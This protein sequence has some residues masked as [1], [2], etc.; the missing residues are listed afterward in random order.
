MALSHTTLMVLTRD[1]ELLSFWHAAGVTVAGAAPRRPDGIALRLRQTARRLGRPVVGEVFAAGALDLRLD[2]FRELVRRP[3]ATLIG[4]SS[5]LV[6]LPLLTLALFGLS[7]LFFR[8]FSPH[9]E[10]FF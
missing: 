5:Q 1:A 10:D 8:R 4:L 2:H 7:L 9:F 3:R 6:L